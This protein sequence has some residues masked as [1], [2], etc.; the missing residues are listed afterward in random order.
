[1]L[2]GHEQHHTQGFLCESG[3]A[4]GVPDPYVT[5]ASLTAEPQNAYSVV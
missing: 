2:P 4:F 5:V 1:M 3:K